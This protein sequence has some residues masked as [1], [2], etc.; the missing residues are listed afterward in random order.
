[1]RIPIRKRILTDGL[2][3]AVMIFAAMLKLKEWKKRIRKTY[4]FVF[5]LSLSRSSSSDDTSS[6]KN[7]HLHCVNHRASP[8]PDQMEFEN[9]FEDMAVILDSFYFYFSQLKKMFA[10]VRPVSTSLKRAPLFV[11]RNSKTL[12]SS[13]L[14]YV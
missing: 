2:L 5:M 9:G 12:G 4:L 10:I 13:S 8:R 3:I 7:F 14:R 11:Q 1:M 6:I